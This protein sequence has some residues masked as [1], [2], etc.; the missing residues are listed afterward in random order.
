MT[1]EDQVTIRCGMIKSDASQPQLRFFHRVHL[2]VLELA[3]IM[4]PERVDVNTAIT[5]RCRR[6][7]RRCSNDFFL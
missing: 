2:F 1:V 6:P 4:T 5:A 3:L 7:R